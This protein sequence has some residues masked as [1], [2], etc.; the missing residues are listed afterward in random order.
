M[1]LQW[2][3]AYICPKNFESFM[4]NM[5][6]GKNNRRALNMSYTKH[7]LKYTLQHLEYKERK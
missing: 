1:G 3:L 7:T 4:E 5:I 2:S 6:D